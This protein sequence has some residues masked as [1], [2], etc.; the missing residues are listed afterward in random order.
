MIPVEIIYRLARCAGRKCARRSRMYQRQTDVIT[1]AEV[2]N[3]FMRGV[4]L[5]M[6]I[7]LVV[8]A[9]AGW[10]TLNSQAMIRLV[11]GSQITY[12]GLLVAEVLLVFAI[13]G[14]INRLSG[15]MATGLFLLYS[16]LN[17]ITLSAIM[18]VYTSTSV[19]QAFF[20]AAGMFGAMSLYG[21]VTKRDLTGLG[22]FM[23][24]GAFGILIAM[25]VNMF[26]QSSALSL[27]ISILGV[28]IFMG[29][30]AYDTQY[31][32]QM[33]ESA[34]MD[35]ATAIRRGT[36]LGALKLYLDFINIFLFLLRLMGDRR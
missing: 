32:R 28:I 4:Y 8:T 33:G 2:T 18:I 27:G 19:F 34:P 26:V 13:S 31:L 10:F 35:D 1:R 6:T 21:L 12:I 29:L 11:F 20:T 25:V 36:I 23:M 22:S 14:M 15:P 5:W 30:T 24:M 17:G 16:A 3:A 7:G 9:V